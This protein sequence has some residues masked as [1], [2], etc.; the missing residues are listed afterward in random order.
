LTWVLGVS[1]GHDASAC[2]L[3]NG[4]VAFHIEEERLTRVKNAVPKALRDLWP[5]FAG[6]FGYFPWASV[7]YCLHA[8]KI[9]IDELD[10]L[11]LPDD[12]YAGSILEIVP[13]K[14]RRKVLVADEPVGGAHHYRHGLSAFLASPFESSA[15]LVIDGDGSV[16]AGGYEAE[17][18]YIFGS[19]EGPCEQVFKNR[20]PVEGLRAG[21]RAGLGWTYDYASAV[22]GFVN[23]R[24]GYLSE[25]GKTMG[26]APY[27]RAGTG[28]GS[29]WIRCDGFQVD[30]SGFH[31]WLIGTG[32]FKLMSFENRDRALVQNEGAIAQDAKDLASR[33]QS[34]LERAILHLAE[35]LQAATG[36]K[37]LCLAG[38]VALNSVANGKL[39]HSRAF[40]RI[41]IQPA[42]ADDGQAIGLAYWGHGKVAASV[43]IPPI[44][45]AFGGRTYAASEI[46]ELVSA[47]GLRVTE[48]NEDLGLCADAAAELAAGKIIGWF[49]GGSEYGPR[50]LGHRSILACPRREEMKDH[51]NARVK[52]REPFRPFAPSVLV[53]RCAEIFE[54][55]T[56]SP[57]MLLVAQ[58]RPAWRAR[59]PA[60]AHVDGSARIQT[61]DAAI[62]PLFHQLI[63]AFE[64]AT[65]VPLVLN[66]SF[67]LRG[68]PIVE[69]PKDALQ[70]FLYT[71][72]DALYLGRQ[73]V[74]R[75]DGAQIVPRIAPRWRFV[76]ENEIASSGVKAQSFRFETAANG[77][78]RVVPVRP[79]PELAALSAALERG[80]TLGEALCATLDSH[81]PEPTLLASTVSLVQGLLRSGALRVGVGSLEL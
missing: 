75:P 77:G 15:V 40:E 69:T 73:K 31:A 48:F 7:S 10:A 8:A 43:R 20:Y 24:I 2:L 50:S 52:F 63:S 25:P 32:L 21:L 5:D 29:D 57:Y 42:S 51:L 4:E 23:T 38:G 27:G 53:E 44:R 9:G 33:V 26:L 12:A 18:G 54:L 62:D 47:S 41:F 45:H 61:V 60:I 11:V 59:V 71:E 74:H 30:F 65:G 78:P 16:A 72:M 67:N 37:N 19:R 22:L 58:V 81:R 80:C 14:D 76:A 34:E 28:D 55:E 66:T 46:A 39:L 17:S 36:A 1:F 68:M 56:E 79:S 13:M 3:R 64:A 6:H 70:C 35:H 49:Q